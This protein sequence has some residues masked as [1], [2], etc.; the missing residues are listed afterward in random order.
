MALGGGVDWVRMES[1]KDQLVKGQF[2]TTEL[3]TC[4]GAYVGARLH[5]FYSGIPVPVLPNP[6]PHPWR[7]NAENVDT[8]ARGLLRL[9]PGVCRALPL[10]RAWRREFCMFVSPEEGDPG[11]KVENGS[12]FLVSLGQSQATELNLPSPRD[13]PVSPLQFDR[14]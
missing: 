12:T 13:C 5:P 7:T 1:G 10:P 14:C 3:E 8:P 6:D 2:L 4:V 9:T 11:K